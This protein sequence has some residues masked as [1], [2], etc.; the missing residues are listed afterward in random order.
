[1]N[2]LFA[3]YPPS[4]FSCGADAVPGPEVPV[5]ILQ[6]NIVNAANAED[7]KEAREKYAELMKNRKYMEGV[8]HNLIDVITN[9]VGLTN[10]IF[11]DNVELT[12]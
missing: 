4:W 10:T 8:V 2:Q 11:T 5:K 9:D 7:A 3:Q 6:N 12:Q 1:M